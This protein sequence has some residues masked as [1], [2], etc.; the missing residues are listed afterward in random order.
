MKRV[1]MLFGW[2]VL[3]I[4]VFA[5]A[6]NGEFSGSRALSFLTADNMWYMTEMYGSIALFV[7]GLTSLVVARKRQ[8]NQ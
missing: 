4:P 5:Y 2:V 3:C 7:V 6:F 1:V 8:K